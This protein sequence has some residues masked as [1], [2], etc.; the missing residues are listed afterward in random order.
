MPLEPLQHKP[1]LLIEW[2]CKRIKT[3]YNNYGNK[4]KFNIK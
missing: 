2:K 3:I 4:I 1:K